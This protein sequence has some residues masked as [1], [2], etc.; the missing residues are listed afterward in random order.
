MAQNLSKNTFPTVYKDDFLD[1]DNYYRILFNSGKKLQARELTQAQT[2]INKQ[3][4]RFGSNIF[5][6][7]ALIKGGQDDVD[8]AYEYIKIN[9]A[10]F[11]VSNPQSLVGFTFTGKSSLVEFKVAEVVAAAGA[12]P[13]TLY[14]T[15]T[16]TKNS[17]S[18]T[19]NQIRCQADELLENNSFDDLQVESST[20]C[21]GVGSRFMCGEA[22]YYTKGF[23]V[24][25]RSQSV[26][27]S[28][29]TTNPT[30]EVGYKRQEQTISSDDDIDLYDNQGSEPNLS[31]SGADRY[32]ISLT[33]VNKSTLS[34]T[35]NFIA[36]ATI[37]NG[38]IVTS[39]QVLNAY[40]VPNQVIAQRIH[41]NSGDYLIKPFG[42]SYELDSANTHLLA[43]LTDGVAVVQGYRTTQ[44]VSK[45]SIRIPRSTAT[46]AYEDQLVAAPYANYFQA[47]SVSGL[48]SGLQSTSAWP[49][50]TLKDGADFGGAS[51]GTCF[52]RHTEAASSGK[53][54]FYVFNVQLNAGK[55]LANIKSVGT[56]NKRFFNVSS[57]PINVT[58]TINS[59][60]FPL[61]QARPSDIVNADYTVQRQF[62]FTPSGTTQIQNASGSETFLDANQWLVTAED[63]NAAS[64]PPKYGDL[65]SAANSAFGISLGSG[66]TQATITG[67]STGALTRVNGFVRKVN[68][69]S[70]S[71]VKTSLNVVLT[72]DSDGT[73][74][75][76]TQ[77]GYGY[78]NLGKPDILGCTHIEDPTDSNIS[79]KSSFQLDNGQR[80][81]YYDN[82]KLILNGV[83][84]AAF[85]T[86]GV[87][88]RFDYFEHQ[89]GDTFFSKNSYNGQ[90][91]YD[92]IPS[93]TFANGTTVNLANVLDFRPT[94]DTNGKFV[95]SDGAF[96]NE[97]P[98]PN[99]VIDLN[100]TYFQ[101]RV[102]R[103]A[104]NK[105]GNIRYEQ[106]A[107]SPN[108]VAPALHKDDMHLFDI[109]MGANTLGPK[110]LQIRKI[111][112][113]RYT[114]KLINVLEKRLNRLEEI[115]TLSLLETKADTLLVL[116]ANGD[117]RLKSGFI[118][119]NF[120]S[121][122][123]SDIFNADHRAS[124]DLGAGVLYPKKWQGSVDLYYD[125]D[126]NNLVGNPFQIMGG[127]IVPKFDREIYLEN[128][129]VSSKMLVNPFQV[130][131][132]VGTM[133]LF[134]ASDTWFETV[135]SGS[136][137]IT[138]AAPKI[139]DDDS[140]KMNSH[141]WNWKGKDLDEL[142]VGDLT[143][144]TES[145]SGRTTT[146]SWNVVEEIQ[147][148]QV[149]TGT[150]LIA[151][152]N[153]QKMRS[154][155]VRFKATGCRPNAKLFAFFDDVPVDNW[156]KNET[157]GAS[158]AYQSAFNT[159]PAYG[160]TLSAS[161]QHPDGASQLQTNDDG[162]CEGSFF[163]PSGDPTFPCG[164]LK[165]EIRDVSGVGN[166]GWLSR[167]VANYTAQGTLQTY[168][169][170]YTST[171]IIQVESDE[172]I[173]TEPKAV[174]NSNG[175]GGDGGDGKDWPEEN[176]DD[177]SFANNQCTGKDG[178]GS[179]W[180]V[181]LMNETAKS[182][183]EDSWSYSSSSSSSNTTWMDNNGWF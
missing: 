56:S 101:P 33:L 135:Y 108:P 181:S 180:V 156:V 166:T 107:A 179:D 125:S 172:S 74:D 175:G 36:R 138:V 19:T 106:G 11:P 54:N 14:G 45:P 159:D 57:G 25:T 52:I 83:K 4:Q 150:S 109:F 103:I 47:D 167:A 89:A 58:N 65:D 62:E 15:Y 173:Y 75:P 152:S 92:Q 17:A 64:A 177:G 5:K 120:K 129:Y 160:S 3:I 32:K 128:E 91:E 86:T 8:N 133:E 157:F 48:S 112:H 30:A 82:G 79:Y 115:T 176:K 84:N 6:D 114:M 39:A 94:V 87:R 44:H 111:D 13:L 29:Y 61:P 95:Y 134:P 142:Q 98:K 63:P 18:S 141:D 151:T 118:V 163:I 123:F 85:S 35:D 12:D 88:V 132:Y 43:N 149:F 102:D 154:K 140:L 1:S 26:I 51:I 37:R 158:T 42:L 41:E 130:N 139:A 96:I 66:N 49:E 116:D 21:V 16:S 28:K 119:D 99:G 90:V 143:N 20:T 55:N 155:K 121:H 147:T 105:N 104:I 164:S 137:A 2:I 144:T 183:Q 31:S 9:T 50:Q 122:A 97:L 73:T 169:N 100:V 72:L 168:Q 23:F 77:T 178:G 34:V 67:L 165:F 53:T 174:V 136:P 113:K 161:S 117:I 80:D 127:Y 153:I 59:L 126:K 46:I 146:T 38:S 22:I 124:I 145:V 10:T 148:S 69:T 24:F 27:L 162:E 71:K 40:N 171:R 170:N 76:A 60:I 78:L 7:N 93:Y 110:D 131:S 68:M 81:N 182:N 70:R